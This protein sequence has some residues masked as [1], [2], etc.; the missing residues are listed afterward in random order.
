MEV[1]EFLILIFAGAM[2]VN[3]L[4]VPAFM[5]IKSD[6]VSVY[7]RI[8]PFVSNPITLAVFLTLILQGLSILV[9]KKITNSL[10]LRKKTR[11]RVEKEINQVKKFLET[12]IKYLNEEEI[13]FYIPLSYKSNEKSGDSFA[14]VR[15]IISFTFS[16]STGASSNI[17]WG[18]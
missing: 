15:Y 4:F 11:E 7:Y 14:L 12:E 17:F 16:L 1:E 2:V 13:T 3:V 9:W 10:R 5:Q 18:R 6:L 8:L